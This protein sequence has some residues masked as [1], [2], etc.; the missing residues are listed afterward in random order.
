MP[1]ET[2]ML[3]IYTNDLF[4]EKAYNKTIGIVISVNTAGYALGAPLA[5][6]CRDIMGDY[7]FSFWA[8]AGIMATIFILI[9]FAINS[10]QKER[11]LVLAME[12]K[13]KLEIEKEVVE[14]E[15]SA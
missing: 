1:L 15:K 3:P 2:I 5:S 8:G 11:K 9:Q 10:A 13:E 14:D 12:E 4:G 6:L 7:N